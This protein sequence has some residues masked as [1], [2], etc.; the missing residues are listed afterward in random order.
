MQYRD[1]FLS[2]G[3]QVLIF[4]LVAARQPLGPRFFYYEFSLRFTNLILMSWFSKTLFI[5][6]LRGPVD[7][8]NCAV[9]SSGFCNGGL[10]LLASMI[11]RLGYPLH[12]NVDITR[13]FSIVWSDFVVGIFAA[14]SVNGLTTSRLCILGWCDEK[15]R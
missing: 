14:R 6:W 5:Y 1:L 13:C 7:V 8:W 10:G 9:S 11:K 2:R 3:L 15:D 4:R 12:C